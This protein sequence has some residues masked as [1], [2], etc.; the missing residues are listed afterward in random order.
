MERITK[1]RKT[2]YS[3]YVACDGTEFETEKAC[4]D[5][6]KSVQGVLFARY[7]SCVINTFSEYELFGVGSDENYI[8]VVKMEDD[9]DINT[10]LQLQILFNGYVK[11][12]NTIWF[13]K[14]KSYFDKGSFFF[15]LRGYEND[16]FWVSKSLEES[17]QNIVNRV[18]NTL[19][20]NI[21]ENFDNE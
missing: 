20:V 7:K 14:L 12:K 9:S 10:I 1:E 13:D 6:E 4:I 16:A 3:V 19:K 2:T 17:I 18:D 15:I 5:Y 8:D 11:D 21:E